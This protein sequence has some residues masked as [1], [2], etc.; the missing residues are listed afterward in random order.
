MTKQR[1]LS[2]ICKDINCP[3]ELSKKFNTW[4]R[5]KLP[6]SSSGYSASDLDFILWNWQTKKYMLLEI[7]TRNTNIRTGQRYMWKNLN[8]WLKAG[9]SNDW[10]YKG[11]HLIKFE[12]TNF[13]DG[14]CY[15]DNLLVTE[16]ELINKLSFT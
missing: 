14:K 7:K 4:V 2:W 3:H 15:F 5:N 9:T 8:N 12:N 11:F 10:E 1:P 16:I 13:E 6:D